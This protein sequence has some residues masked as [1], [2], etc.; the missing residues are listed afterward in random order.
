MAKLKRKALVDFSKLTKRELEDLSLKWEKDA[1]YFEAKLDR[2]LQ[3]V[4]YEKK[5][6]S[7]PQETQIKIERLW[8]TGKSLWNRL[9]ILEKW[10]KSN[11]I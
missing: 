9:S 7:V 8:N 2:L 6:V 10:K 11:R 1:F 4:N 3:N 5:F